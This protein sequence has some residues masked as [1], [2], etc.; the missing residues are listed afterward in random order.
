MLALLAAVIVLGVT[1]CASTWDTLSSKRFREKPW[2]TAF[3]TDDPLQ[4]LRTSSD[5]E[6]RARA[7][8]RLKEPLADGRS[9]ADQEVAFEILATAAASDPSPWVRM[10][11]IDALG[12]FQD[13][14][15]TE[16]LAVAFHQA[17]G[18]PANA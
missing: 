12:R 11:A 17:T 18:K 5:G 14:R 8:R 13:P 2:E 16:A 7:M 1:G 4:V 15:A 10:A 6:E 3:G 9:E